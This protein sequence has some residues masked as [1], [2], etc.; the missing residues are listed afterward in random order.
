M[1]VCVRVM[2]FRCRSISCFSAWYYGKSPNQLEP[3]E[4]TW[5]QI[6]RT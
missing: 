3:L 1:R 5:P 4:A 6:L 2:H